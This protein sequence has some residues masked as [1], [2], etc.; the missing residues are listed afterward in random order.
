MQRLVTIEEVEGV[1]KLFK[2][3]KAPGPDGFNLHF[4]QKCWSIVREDVWNTVNLFFQ[5]ASF[6]KSFNATFI[7]LIPKKREAEK[8]K[9]FRPISLL[10]SV[11]KIIAKLLVER[12]KMVI[13]NLIFD[14]QIAFIRERHIVDASMVANEC[15]EYMFKN[16]RQEVLC[17]LD[18]EKTYDHV[19]WAFLTGVIRQMSFGGK[20]IRWIDYCISTVR[21]LVLINGSPQG[22]FK[23][24]RG[25]RQG[26]P[27]SPYLFVLVMKFFSNMLKKAESMG[28]IRGLH[29][30]RR[31]G[32]SYDISHRPSY[33]GIS[34][35]N[36]V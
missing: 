27:L 3:D 2:G 17:K 16:K 15:V 34:R 21:F 11:Y 28:W 35:G 10:G 4:F 9:D 26:V 31:G 29:N 32:L 33:R 19:N 25:I 18:L 20:W 1:V 22:F 13:G 30:S 12:L 14:N 36:G 24:T 5:E 6:T 23:S 8:I 7:S